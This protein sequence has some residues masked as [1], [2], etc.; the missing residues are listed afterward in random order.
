MS[1]SSNSALIVS[2]NSGDA[3]FRQH[4][5]LGRIDE[6]LLLPLDRFAGGGIDD[7]K[8]LDFIPP[9]LD[10]QG[11]FASPDGPKLERNRRAPELPA[12]RKSMSFRRSYCTSFQLAEH[13]VAIDL[14]AAAMAVA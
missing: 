13:F 5:M 14:L 10:P 8:L 2:I 7:R 11:I 3:F 1:R 4:E 9:E 6:K 12:L